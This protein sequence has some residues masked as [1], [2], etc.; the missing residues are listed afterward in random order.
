[1]LDLSTWPLTHSSMTVYTRPKG[2][3]TLLGRNFHIAP[4]PVVVV[5]V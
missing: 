5:T 4:P 1:M 2:I 3:R